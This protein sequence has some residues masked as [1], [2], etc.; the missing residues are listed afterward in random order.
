MKKNIITS[1][2][3][4]LFS[5]VFI[6]CGS[7]QSVS[8]ID[9]TNTN[10]DPST[11]NIFLFGTDFVSSGQLML[12]DSSEIGTLSNTGV[13][14]LGSSAV[15]RSYSG[16]LYVLHDGYS[17]GSLDNV[18]ILDP[19]NGFE[20][21]AQWSTGNGTNPQDIVV[22]DGKAYITLYDPQNDPENVDAAGNPGDLIVMDLD[23]G[24]IETRISFTDYLNSD[25]YK[26]A[27]AYRMILVDDRLYV[28]VQD[29]GEDAAFG[30]FSQ[31]AAGKIAVVNITTREVE[32]V[33][34]LKG[35]NP[36]DIEYSE[37]EDKLYV[38]HLAP[39]DFAI[40]NFNTALPYGGLEIIPQSDSANSVLIHDDD[41]D[42]YVERLALGTNQ[43]IIVVSEM[44]PVSFVFSS[45]L[46]TMSVANEELAGISLFAAG[47]SDVRD[48]VVDP[49][50]RL[51]V[52]H[53]TIAAGE[54]AS[55]PHVDV[56]DLETGE[57][58][59]ES[60]IPD[61]LVPVTSIAVGS[62]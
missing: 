51:W 34:T 58:I 14:G 57:N 23:T 43:L 25:D 46:L 30:L 9:E 47:S 59:G 31:N 29:L 61:P 54:E 53:R 18:Q 40:G 60:I 21:V 28:C 19:S 33:I 35:R 11:I 38:V 2:I 62:L 6:H 20:T 37:S 39:Y 10:I 27:R 45:S 48:I 4:I 32:K 12:A 15:I 5:I 36:V 50:D 44:D 16:L 3:F 56:F 42:G 8:P 7:L 26:A 1:F 17:V 52:A 49:L 22:V 55:D 41:L 13:T 24:A